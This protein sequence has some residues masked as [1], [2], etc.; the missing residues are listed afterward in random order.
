VNKKSNLNLKITAKK[1]QKKLK[2]I[3]LFLTDCD[4]VMTNGQIF[5]VSKEAG[6]SRFFHSLDGYGLKCL[7]KAGIEIGVISGGKSE[8]LKQRCQGLGIDHIYLGDEDKRSAYLEI[9]DKTGLKDDQVLYI[10][11]DLFDLPILERVGFS[12]AVP[13]S[14]IEVHEMVDY[15]TVK[16][17]GLGAVRE[18]CDLVRYAQ[19]I[20]S[21]VTTF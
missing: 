13:N 19:G 12:A 18:V 3:K 9:L 4:G 14:V 10:G 6:W 15:V 16:E 7:Q 5:W 17:G 8:G 2:K 1:F 21:E 11:D 20:K